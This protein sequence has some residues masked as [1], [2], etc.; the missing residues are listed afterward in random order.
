MSGS[1]EANGTLSKPPVK[2][3]IFNKP[4][5]SKP[6]PMASTVDMFSR[7][8]DTYTDI[9]AEEKRKR[10]ERLARKEQQRILRPAPDE[11]RESKRRRVTEECGDD[12][13]ASKEG[14]DALGNGAQK[15]HNAVRGS[16]ERGRSTGLPT[17]ESKLSPASLSKRYEAAAISREST[18]KPAPVAVIDLEDED[19]EDEDMEDDEPHGHITM[20]DPSSHAPPIEDDSVASDE[21]FPELARKARERAR[22]KSNESPHDPITTLEPPST[23]DK[24]PSIPRQIPQRIPTPPPDPIVKILITSDIPDTKPLI[25]HRRLSQRLKDVKVMW[26]KKQ[27]FTEDMCDTIHLTWQ[28]HKLFNVTTCKTLGMGVD[29]NGSLVLKG[30]KD[31]LGDDDGRIHMEAMTDEMIKQA[32]IAKESLQSIHDPAE[33]AEVE[34]EP[35]AEP[36]PAEGIKIVLVSRGYEDFKLIVKPSTPI[37]RIVGVFRHQYQVT[38]DKEVFLIFD[39]DRLDVDLSVGDTDLSDLDNV[40]VHVKS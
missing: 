4:S 5:W 11:I 2:R 37:S 15:I 16:G 19:T 13:H 9:V 33:N 40:E 14:D 17:Q 21:E 8:N 28:G 12:G 20:N 32:Q 34:E 24:Q 39:G 3:S 36:K 29:E 27:G 22:L 10:Q 1:G 26:C 38:T 30:E 25:V 7:S 35:V 31:T 23:T 18:P 6:Q